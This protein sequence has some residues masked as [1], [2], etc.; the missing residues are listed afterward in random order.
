MPATLKKWG[1]VAKLDLKGPGLRE[2]PALP[3]GA[4][5]WTLGPA[6][7]LLTCAADARESAIARMEEMAGVW[8]TDVTEVYAHF[9]LSGEHGRDLL[10]KVTSL[11][12]LD[13]SLPTL[14]CAQTRLAHVHAILMRQDDAFHI[15]VGREYGESVWAALRHA[16][17][18]FAL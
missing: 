11:N 5:T 16:A 10:R 2:L 15:L 8:V 12:V 3:G 18:E 14:A 7:L 9:L 1:G 4:R 17:V 13:S 6:H